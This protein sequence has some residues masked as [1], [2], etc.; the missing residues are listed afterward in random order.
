MRALGRYLKEGDLVFDVGA[1]IGNHTLYFAGCCGCSVTAFEPHPIAASYLLDNVARNGLAGQVVVQEA[2]LGAFAGHARFGSTPQHNLGA[3]SLRWDRD[4]EV[5]V[6]PLDTFVDDRPV[7]LVKID[8][9]GMELEVLQGAQALIDRDHPIIACEIWK[10]EDFNNIADYLFNF[11]YIAFGVYNPTPTHVFR[12]ISDDAERARMNDAQRH[13]ALQVIE[14]R[15]TQASTDAKVKRVE[16]LV[17]EVENLSSSVETSMNDRLETFAA[18]QARDDAAQRDWLEQ[19]AQSTAALIK[20]EFGTALSKLT[21]AIETDAERE[22]A[23]VVAPLT[24]MVKRQE[25]ASSVG[26]EAI[27]RAQESQADAIEALDARLTGLIERQESAAAAISDAIRS[28]QETQAGAIA[29]LT[30]LQSAADAQKATL[31]EEFS[32]LRAAMEPVAAIQPSLEATLKA[33]AATDRR[34]LEA[35][36]DGA[37]GGGGLDGLRSLVADTANAAISE[38]RLASAALLEMQTLLATQIEAA[39]QVQTKSLERRMRQSLDD[40]A[41]GAVR[42][43]LRTGVDALARELGR[44]YADFAVEADERLTAS[45]VKD[46]R[47][48]QGEGTGAMSAR[49]S[50]T[51]PRE[52]R[53]ARAEDGGAVKRKTPAA[54]KQTDGSTKPISAHS[55]YQK[56]LQSL[57]GEYF[58]KVRKDEI[59]F[60]TEYLLTMVRLE[61][62]DTAYRL[63]RYIFASFERVPKKHRGD[64]VRILGR[65]YARRPIDPQIQAAVRRFR[66]LLKALPHTHGH[67]W[68]LWRGVEDPKPSHVWAGGTSEPPN[69]SDLPNARDALLAPILRAV[70]EGRGGT[71]KDWNAYFEQFTVSRSARI[72]A[73]ENF[74]AGLVFEPM[75][76]RDGP[77]VSVIMSAF[78][79]EDTVAYAIRS[80]LE[81]SYANIELLVCDDQ[82][83]DRTLDCIKKFSSDTR[84]KVRQSVENQGTYNI[85]NALIGEARG[86]YVTFMDSDDYALPDRLE[87]QMAA[88]SDSDAGRINVGSWLRLDAQ[89]RPKFFSDRHAERFCVVS[90]LYE[91]ET[92][93][94]VGAYLPALVAADTDHY[95]RA[96]AL[97]PKTAFAH[98]P[99]WPLFLGLISQSSLS[100]RAGLEAGLDGAVS[101]SRQ[102]FIDQASRARILGPEIVPPQ[103][104]E[105]VMSDLDILRRYAGARVIGER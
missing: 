16:R 10:A 22:H 82:S 4:G 36:E 6:V 27:R 58:V 42:E 49:R 20:A 32:P 31:A 99:G 18:G 79:A 13:L 55:P 28:L 80:I 2:A 95:E 24:E 63:A 11:G 100:A 90:I 19:F 78:N 29:Q 9:E 15:N 83:E 74:L 30:A 67:D 66:D 41:R 70:A 45:V 40:I 103:D 60:L 61:L 46:T 91:R 8:V 94:E 69:V 71:A 93:N 65:L 38:A 54:P 44:R 48:I 97:F 62:P 88:I 37:D 12:Y 35:L 7:R 87:R 102:K 50:Q 89:G 75:P 53:T 96:R 77:L 84:L 68:A 26:I 72:D 52:V 57:N 1:N 33:L 64:I 56:K 92:L 17:R 98:H 23:R 105:R 43:E 34:L 39:L 59:G 25:D 81:Q 14:Q 101:E 51:A 21:D 73:A 85:R 3:A 104:V 5:E 86:D 76:K 47:A